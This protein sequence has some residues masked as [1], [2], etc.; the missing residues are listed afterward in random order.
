MQPSSPSHW[1]KDVA[2]HQIE[3]LEHGADDYVLKPVGVP[4]CPKCVL[5]IP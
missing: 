3:L 4:F 5:R 2:S 1:L